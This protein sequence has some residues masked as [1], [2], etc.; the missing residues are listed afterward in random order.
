M[1]DELSRFAYLWDGT[2]AGWV[3]VRVKDRFLVVN[4]QG[5][6]ALLIC[7][8]DSTYEAVCKRMIAE[9]CEILD[10]VPGGRS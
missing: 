9:G 2:Q 3:L 1:T 6:M 4:K 8:D 7:E 10:E 5:H